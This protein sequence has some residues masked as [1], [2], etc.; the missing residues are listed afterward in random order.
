MLRTCPASGRESYQVDARVDP[1]RGVIAT[2]TRIEIDPASGRPGQVHLWLYADRMQHVPPSFDELSAERIYVGGTSLG[3]Y[4][5]LHV[6]VEG[7]PEQT[8][9]AGSAETTHPIRGRILGVAICED[10]P[11]PIRL[12]V[13][14]QLRLARRYGTLGHAHG[15]VHLGDPWYPL[16]LAGD[17]LGPAD[18]DHRVHVDV[19]HGEG[20]LLVGPDGVRRGRSAT[21]RANAAS[22]VPL[23]VLPHGFVRSAV[24]G[25]VALEVVTRQAPLGLGR[26]SD[27]DPSGGVHPFEP[28]A[29][30]RISGAVREAVETL[31]SLGFVAGDEAGVRRM[32]RRLTV[33]EIESRQR[34]AVA[35]PGML[36]VSDRAFRLFPLERIERFHRVGLWRGAFAA[37]L[38]PHLL[39]T[40]TLADR[41][42]VPDA[43][44]TLLVDLGLR[45]Q[46]K[47]RDRPEDLVGFA[48]FHPAVDQ[49][50]YAPQVRFESVYFSPPREND[51][52]RHGAQRALNHDPFGRL[53]HDKLR[54]RLGAAAQSFWRSHL[55]DGRP[56]RDAAQRA[57]NEPL[58]WFFEQWLRPPQ[59]VA[60]RLGQVV[61]EETAD[62]FEHTVQVE[63][64]GDTSLRESVEVELTDEQGNR[65]RV[66]WDEAGPSGRVLLVTPA[67]LQQ[68]EL[69]P[70]GR[71][72][73]DPGLTR[74]HPK[75]DNRL[76]RRWRPPI[77]NNLNVSLS[78]LELEPDVFA[79]FV[80]KPKYDVRNAIHLRLYSEPRGYGASV[81][82]RRGLGELRDLNGTVGRA[83]F[84]L[85]G[86]RSDGGFANTERGVS[87]LLLSASLGR[88]T[89]VQIYDPA[90]GH[91]L[92]V[93]G[94][95]GVDRQDGGR[96]LVAA[97]ASVRGQL[98]VWPH[99]EHILAVTGGAQLVRCPA[100][101]QALPSLGGRHYLRAYE[102]DELLGCAAA[103]GIVEHRWSPIRGYYVNAA[104]LA[105]AR[106]LELVPFLA[107]G[108]VSSGDTALDLFSRLHGEVGMGL[109]AFFDHAGIQPGMMALDVAY[110]LTD[111]PRCVEHDETGGCL[112]RRAPFGMHVSF[113][114]TF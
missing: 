15:A 3:G 82:Y 25:G 78:V 49:L 32:A 14:S 101:P 68:V 105:W 13:R 110:P 54:P 5:A 106:R 50:L 75:L 47:Q 99:V 27:Q 51:P 81:R 16:L 111:S 33:V 35:V 97:G 76:S 84:G 103:Y 42:W 57:A 65:R 83:G 53:L 104:N 61:T 55:I 23:F 40:E 66:S 86:L 107:G 41:R 7:C 29:A 34:L 91:A 18:G 100:L 87:E 8:F 6:K 28:D 45:R 63:R 98:L 11:T 19:E 26:R 69:D 59:P 56:W 89:R 102:A 70:D 108:L 58:R 31:R 64:L 73:E 79:D 77:F 62:G 43:D 88:D 2:D 114:Q 44:A 36:A 113:E 46:D 94:H 20:H 48:G 52:D 17:G 67:P 39:A 24:V 72:W 38:R 30:M 71:L 95:V 60:Y 93:G 109:R 21:L 85:S 90:S 112:R 92:Y 12:R 1:E 10:A 4:G 96:T 37:L 22:H 9:P 80:M 74:D